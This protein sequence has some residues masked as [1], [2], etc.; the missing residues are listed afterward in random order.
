MYRKLLALIGEGLERKVP[1]TGVGVFRIGYGLVALQEVLFL[2]YFRHLI[3]DPVPYLD[4]ASPILHFFLLVWMGV[5]GCL[6]LG[7]HTRKAALANYAFWVV[8]V[9]F[10]PM[11]QDFDGGFD[12]LMTGTAFLLIFLPSERALSLDNLRLK[13]RY[14]APGRPFVPPREVSVLAYTLPVALCLGLVYFDSGLHKLSAEFWRN[15]LGPWLPVTMPY[16][17]SPIDMSPLLN[18]E[19]LE[20]ILGYT[21]IVFQLVFLF[22]FWFRRFR[23]PLLL[24]GASF[25]TGIILSLNVYPFGFGMLVQ[26]ALL[27]PFRWWRGLG[28]AIGR[29]QPVLAVFYDEQCPL[30][31]RTVLCIEHFDFLGAIEFKGLQTHARQYRGLDAIPGETLLTDLYALDRKGRLSAGLDTYIAILVKMG[32]TAPVGWVMRL[33][34]LYGYAGRV[35]R[36]IADNRERQICDASCAAPVPE[37]E[38]ER[39]FAKLY[40]RHAASDRQAAQRIAKFLVLVLVLQLNCTIHYALLYRW[41]GTRPSDPALALLDQFSDT[42][43]NY[44]HAFLGISPHALYMH[45]H[46]AGYNHLLAIT[47]RDKGGRETWLPFVNEEGRLL[48]PNWGR[49]QSMWANVAI[50]SHMSRDRLEKFMRKL[51]A[52]YGPDMGVDLADAEFVIKMKEVRVPVEWEYDLRHRNMAAPWR[53]VGTVSWKFDGMRLEVPGLATVLG[54]P[55]GAKAARDRPDGGAFPL[56]VP[57]R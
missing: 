7:L 13:L 52:F 32:Y 27:V 3:F 47:Y 35:Y 45:D 14:S 26:Y 29:K 44:S 40:A 42:V 24:M 50:T 34:G 48:T 5:A 36:K 15:G 9:V 20:K 53:D 49:V 11:W 46:F 18:V 4:R 38:D 16:Y 31:N 54:K 51:T 56:S 23:V 19:F 41:A 39:P 43:I 21:V 1:A 25:H 22:L 28:K 2:F 37:I 30:C 10:T 8:F 55:E 17:V 6:V 33:P 57:G 12:Q